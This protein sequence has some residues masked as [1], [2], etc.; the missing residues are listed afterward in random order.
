MPM[1]IKFY[2][3]IKEFP[4]IND[5]LTNNSKIIIINALFLEK[6]LIFANFHEYSGNIANICI[7]A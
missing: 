2:P 3:T 4:R 6:W 7:N 5:K 1:P